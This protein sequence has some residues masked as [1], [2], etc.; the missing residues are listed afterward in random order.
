MKSEY[1]GLLTTLLLGIFILIGT[2]IAFLAKKRQKI[3]DFSLALAFSVII[4]LIVFDLLP[5][6]SEL[7]SLKYIWLFLIGVVVG[8]VLLKVLDNFIP[9]HNDNKMN[10]KEL[11]E[12]LAHI[13]IVSSI[14]LVIHNIIE[15]MAVYQTVL[16]SSTTGLML[17]IGVGF[18]NLPLGMVIATTF[19]QA[20]QSKKKTLIATCAISLS[21]LLGGVIMF[22]LNN[23][24]VN[25]VLLGTL[26]SITLGMLLYI[27]F[28][29][30]YP[31]VKKV[32]YKT[33]RNIGI[34]LGIIIMIISILI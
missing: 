23:Q 31:R 32:K 7:L 3:I 22:L 15:G 34:L 10:N 12:N 26:L 33:A 2:L 28:S 1:I 11:K 18:H 30:L 4:M 16:S 21:T 27:A 29:E 8:Y 25:S 5:E 9:D 17:A 14:A 20:N 19:Y 24:T 13:G 6:I